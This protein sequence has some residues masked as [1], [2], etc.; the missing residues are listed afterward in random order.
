[1]VGV[2]ATDGN[3]CPERQRLNLDTCQCEPAERCSKVS[4]LEFPAASPP[5]V[6]PEVPEVSEPRGCQ[7]DSDCPEGEAC[8]GASDQRRGTCKKPPPRPRST[9]QSAEPSQCRKSIDCPVGQV[10]RKGKCVGEDEPSGTT[11][12]EVTGSYTGPG[13]IRIGP[14]FGTQVGP[15]V[16]GVQPGSSGVQ[17]QIVP[18]IT[19]QMPVQRVPRRGKVN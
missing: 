13:S 15:G 17:R 8:H 9:V 16:G 11:G 4:R 14:Q 7:S 6:L 5:S 1:M 3:R 12:S 2:S 18:K 19:P 10:C